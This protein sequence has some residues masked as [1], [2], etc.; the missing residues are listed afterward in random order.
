M[1]T[2]YLDG[3]GNPNQIVL[4]VGQVTKPFMR[5]VS[6]KV[7]EKEALEITAILNKHYVVPVQ[8]EIKD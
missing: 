4:T 3:Y 7:D 1:F 6:K 8:A 2:L 5:F